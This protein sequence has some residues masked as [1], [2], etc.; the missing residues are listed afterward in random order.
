MGSRN[1]PHIQRFLTGQLLV[2]M[3][4][5]PDPRFARSVVYICAHTEDGAMGL[6]I[7]QLFTGVDS[8]ELLEQ[9]GITGAGDTAHLPIHQG[10]PVEQGRGFVLHTRDYDRDGT[11]PIEEDVALTAT[12]D[13]L[14][15][16]AEGHGPRRSLLALGYAGWGA[17]Q[18]DHEMLENGW[19]H[20][21]ADPD[22]LFDTNY[23][24]KWERAIA[25]M[26]IS[27]PRLSA[28]VGHA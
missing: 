28:D 20:V 18:L 2:A 1:K 7:N 24:D 3:P 11:L 19:L 12:I 8:A 9:L 14:R 17:G 23:D 27:L 6:I 21:P 26:G 13:I 15:A 16:M 5:M 4:G 10:G 22:L 25:K